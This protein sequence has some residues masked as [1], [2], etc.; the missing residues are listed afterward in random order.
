VSCKWPLPNFPHQNSIR[1]SCFPIRATYPHI[2]PFSDLQHEIMQLMARVNG[3]GIGTCGAWPNDRSEQGRFI[4]PSPPAKPQTGRAPLVGC[5]RL[6]IHYFR[7][8]RS[9]LEAVSSTR[10]LRKCHAVVIRDTL[11]VDVSDETMI[12]STKF[13][14]VLKYVSCFIITVHLH[15]E[16][17]QQ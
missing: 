4:T 10:N 14:I 7:G 5:S 9:Y 12:Y 3:L 13:S 15:F 17:V 11:N 16:I 6:L 8:Y 1:I 2:Q